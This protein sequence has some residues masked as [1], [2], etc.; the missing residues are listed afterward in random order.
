MY[1]TMKKTYMTPALDIQRVQTEMMIA[2]SITKIGGDSGLELGEGEAPGEADVKD[3]NFFGE[4]IF[5]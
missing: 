3:G 5:D 4:S 1:M 2:A